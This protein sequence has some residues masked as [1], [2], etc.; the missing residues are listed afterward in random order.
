MDQKTIYARGIEKSRSIS[1]VSAVHFCCTMESDQV[2]F[3][4]GPQVNVS[5]I[6]RDRNT[7]TPVSTANALNEECSF[8]C[9][10]SAHGDQGD[11]GIG[12]GPSDFLQLCCPFH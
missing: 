9:P 7:C 3:C 6:L 2:W 11:G 5:R 4:C 12:E 1:Q 8:L 10:P